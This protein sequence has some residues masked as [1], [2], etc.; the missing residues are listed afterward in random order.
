MKAIEL[1][2]TGKPARLAYTESRAT[3]RPAANEVLLRV[4]AA[5]LNR[6]DQVL[7]MGYPGLT[8]E[9]PHV[10]GADFA[11]EIA[12]IGMGVTDWSVGERASVYPLVA[13]GACAL[14][15]EGRPNLCMHFQYF[16]MHRPGG[17][18]EFVTVPA[19]NLCRIPDALD[20][21]TAASAGVAGITAL[22]A[23]RENTNLRRGDTI[24][25]WGATGGVGVFLIQLAR[26][27]GINV[28]AT[29][30]REEAVD[31]LRQLGASHVFTGSPE[32][33][34]EQVRA[35]CPAGVDQVIDYVGPAT[36]TTS[37]QLLKRGGTLT[38]CG[39]L[40]G[41]ETPLSIHQTY[42]RHLRIQGIFLGTRDEYD[43]LLGMLSRN[44]LDI[45]LAARVSLEH[46]ADALQAFSSDGHL[47]KV[48]VEM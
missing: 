48:V 4:R 9:L 42:F 37:H 3:P 40:T 11:G 28:I 17:F 44:A 25:V 10:L 21:A 36:F 33:I 20:F 18:A 45:P 29:T 46:A 31:A 41:I 6:V 43:E 30:R 2:S 38:L 24:L 8:L 39:I 47:G 5:A 27:A 22:H 14:C 1:L 19:D 34:A 35:V 23:L 12:E 15:K 32:A 13:C 26:A 16:G 7:M